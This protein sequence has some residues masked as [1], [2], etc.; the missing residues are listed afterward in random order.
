MNSVISFPVDLSAN[1]KEKEG[2][3]D[4]KEGGRQSR[5]WMKLVGYTS[6]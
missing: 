4:V 3:K 2:K 6:S 5:L 1:D